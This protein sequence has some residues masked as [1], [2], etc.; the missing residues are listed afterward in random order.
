MQALSQEVT[1]RNDE[2]QRYLHDNTPFRLFG[3]APNGHRVFRWQPDPANED[4]YHEFTIGGNHGKGSGSGDMDRTWAI[5]RSRSCMNGKCGCVLSA[6]EAHPE[7]EQLL[8][9]LEGSQPYNVGQQVMVGNEP[10]YVTAHDVI[11]GE[12]VYDVAHAQTGAESQM[13][14]HQQL[15]P[16]L[17]QTFSSVNDWVYH[18]T[19]VA[20]RASISQYGLQMNR[21]QNTARDPGIYFYTD[22]AKAQSHAEQASSNYGEPWEVWRFPR[23]AMT[24]QNALGF[25]YTPENVPASAMQRVASL[26]VKP[27]YYRFTYSPTTGD[28]DLSHN[29]EAHPAAIPTHGDM[30][31]KRPEP[32]LICGYAY[33]IGNGF[34]LTD[35]EDR[36]I[37][38][39]HL[40]QEVMKHIAQAENFT[41]REASSGGPTTMPCPVC[42]KEGCTECGTPWWLNQSPEE[43]KSTV[44]LHYG[45]SMR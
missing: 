11:D 39:P 31:A 41:T 10:H 12:N 1:A 25:H 26:K 19:P 6:G 42:G 28:V 24:E 15:Q 23:P 13:L 45:G 33:R 7:D 27:I 35:A 21:A 29:H 8:S 38:D 37:L 30:A 4:A 3:T 44:R 2:A 18:A 14:E 22:P 43:R 9:Q 17:Q 32:D 5:R 34:R 40:T 20:N 16:A 36:P